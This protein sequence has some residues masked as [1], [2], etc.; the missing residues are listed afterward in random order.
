MI[1]G[2]LVAEMSVIG[3]VLLWLHEVFSRSNLLGDQSPTMLA[4]VS[5]LG[6]LP[7]WIQGVVRVTVWSLLAPVSLLVAVRVARVAGLGRLAP[8]QTP[9]CGWCGGEVN[10]TATMCGSCRASLDSPSADGD[11]PPDLRFGARLSRAAWGLGVLGF[12]GL[13]MLAIGIV[14]GLGGV[15]NPGLTLRSAVVTALLVL[16][17]LAAG[18][19]V[20]VLIAGAA[21]HLR[22]RTHCPRCGLA[23]A[24]GSAAAPEDRTARE[25]RCV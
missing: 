23:R 18:V 20:Y 8:G 25:C 24:L 16:P 5:V 21:V 6:A 11:D 17:M 12:V 22:G 3:W 7:M 10:A 2:V 1:T 19:G 13:L 4:G 9:R 15:W 14:A